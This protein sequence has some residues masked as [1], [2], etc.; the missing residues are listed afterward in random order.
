[1]LTLGILPALESA[2][3]A[4]QVYLTGMDC[5]VA[6]MQAVNKGYIGVDI[7]TQIDVCASEAAK[8]AIALV[9]GEEV[10]Y[11]EMID[12]GDYKV[13]KKYVPIVGVTKDN[14]EEWATQIAPEGWITMEQIESGQ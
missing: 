2:G 13:P 7:W 12:N 9:K 3:L 11:D 5:E 10:D 4:G 14:I 1:M 8:A 6:A